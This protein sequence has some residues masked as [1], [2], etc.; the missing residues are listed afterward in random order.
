MKD[1]FIKAKMAFD[2]AFFLF[3]CIYSLVKFDEGDTYGGCALIVTAILWRRFG[4]LPK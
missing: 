2:F 3:L 4:R 1:Y